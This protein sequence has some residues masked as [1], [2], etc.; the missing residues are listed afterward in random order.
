LELQADGVDAGPF[1][2][3]NRVFEDDRIENNRRELEE[4]SGANVR[5]ELAKR[6][7]RS[8]VARPPPT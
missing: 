3:D 6:F 8:P 4:I 7:L 5:G 2:R 1:A